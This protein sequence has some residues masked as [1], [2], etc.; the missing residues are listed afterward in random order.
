MSDH[1]AAEK[2]LYVSVDRCARKGTGQSSLPVFLMSLND[3]HGTAYMKFFT[4]RQLARS[5]K[6]YKIMEEQTKWQKK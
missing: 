5:Y 1:R 3:T 6:P 4:V 2:F